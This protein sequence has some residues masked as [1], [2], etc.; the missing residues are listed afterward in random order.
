MTNSS[1]GD[2]IGAARAILTQ[3]GALDPDWVVIG[4]RHRTWLEEL[5]CRSV[6]VEVVERA[7]PPVLIVPLDSITPELEAPERDA[8]EPGD[9]A[10]AD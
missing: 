6:A 9:P 7:Q 2:E 4:T 5:A 3:V 1:G 8:C 10:Q